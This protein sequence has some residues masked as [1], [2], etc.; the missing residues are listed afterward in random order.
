MGCRGGGW[1]VEGGGAVF[2][3]VQLSDWFRVTHDGYY[4]VKWSQTLSQSNKSCTLIVVSSGVVH[5]QGA[6]HNPD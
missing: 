2:I 3:E 1:D 5:L 6:S 4:C